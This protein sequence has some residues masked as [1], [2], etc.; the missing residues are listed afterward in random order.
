V[1]SGVEMIGSLVGKGDVSFEGGVEMQPEKII[2]I[3]I[4]MKRRGTLEN[5]IWRFYF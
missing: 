3:T 4:R 1:G 2:K 5:F